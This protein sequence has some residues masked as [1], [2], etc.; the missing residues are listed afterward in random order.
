ML[1][2]SFL[3]VMLAI[4][5]VICMGAFYAIRA[6]IR[7]LRNRHRRAYDDNDFSMPL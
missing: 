1:L 6:L 5:Y 4:P 3:I 2:M 7:A